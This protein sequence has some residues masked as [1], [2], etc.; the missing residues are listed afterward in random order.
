MKE[1][2]N[3]RDCLSNQAKVAYTFHLIKKNSAKVAEIEKITIPVGRSEGKRERKRMLEG[4]CSPAVKGERREE[5]FRGGEKQCVRN[6]PGAYGKK[7]KSP[8][9]PRWV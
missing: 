2:G 1:V 5:R 4:T 7:R 6:F 3:Q 9:V 8:L